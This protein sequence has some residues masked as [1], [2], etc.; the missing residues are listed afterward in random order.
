MSFLVASGH[1]G[2]SISAVSRRFAGYGLGKLEVFP[3]L[4]HASTHVRNTTQAIATRTRIALINPLLASWTGEVIPGQ[5][6]VT[7]YGNYSASSYIEVS[8]FIILHEP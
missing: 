3:I 1:H 7:L 8:R 6:N 5:G 2:C 4:Y